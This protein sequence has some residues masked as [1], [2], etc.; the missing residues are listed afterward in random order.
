MYYL[1]KKGFGPFKKQ[2]LMCK[3]YPSAKAFEVKNVESEFPNI[4]ITML[5]NGNMQLST[6][7]GSTSR[8]ISSFDEYQGVITYSGDEQ[9]GF[10]TRNGRI[11]DTDLG[12]SVISAI[13]IIGDVVVVKQ[14]HK[15][16]LNASYFAVSSEDGRMITHENFE[17]YQ[18]GDKE[19]GLKGKVA[20]FGQKNGLKT[21]ISTEGDLITNDCIKYDIARNNLLVLSQDSYDKNR[22]WLEG[23][24]LGRSLATT[25]IDTNITDFKLSF[26]E[27][28]VKSGAKTCVYEVA[29][30]DSKNYVGT[31]FKKKFEALGDVEDITP[32]FIADRVYLQTNGKTAT[33]LDENG[34]ASNNPDLK[35]LIGV[36]F[37]DDKA[38][39]T[40]VK[41]ADGNRDGLIRCS[42]QAT[43]IRPEYEKIR[44]LGTGKV[45]ASYADSFAIFGLA[46][47][48]ITKD[49]ETSY[50]T[51][52]D[53]NRY[54]YP[55][56]TSDKN[57]LMCRDSN[58]M[59]CILNIENGHPKVTPL[60]EYGREDLGYPTS[61][62]RAN[63]RDVLEDEEAVFGD[64]G[65]S[66]TK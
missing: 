12:M 26:D 1:D 5:E 49:Y 16:T 2:V 62:L 58:D 35:G 64:C 42:D 21:L 9:K 20:I 37:I 15:K 4:Q 7:K 44:S 39:R 59:D 22:N 13:D 32:M 10:I 43:I 56:L 30:A 36:E 31:P 38:I 66:Q 60:P 45:V 27:M 29:D 24:D 23:F 28:L 65:K 48:P 50:S 55:Q 8:E 52:L 18:L 3:P 40:T 17:T 46:T 25:F 41:T 53:F 47:N 57:C 61:K 63:T 6:D 34:V 19:I 33:L 51:V 54:F 14:V 11:V